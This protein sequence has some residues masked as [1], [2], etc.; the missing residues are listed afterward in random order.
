MFK[1]TIGVGG[2]QCEMC[3]SHVTETIKKEFPEARKVSSSRRRKETV[4]ISEAP[5]AEDR[6][7]AAITG[8]GYD[9]LSFRDEPYEEK[10]LLARLKKLF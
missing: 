5:I 1:T 3:E 7:R 9:Y 4:V 10:G 2:M 6:A 8:I